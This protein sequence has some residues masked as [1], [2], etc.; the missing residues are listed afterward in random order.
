MKW[1]CLLSDNRETII[2]SG[3]Q[4]QFEKEFK[5]VEDQELR[6]LEIIRDTSKETCEKL[7]YELIDQADDVKKYFGNC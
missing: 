3:T 4:E 6:R 5:H 1:I 7:A 2:F